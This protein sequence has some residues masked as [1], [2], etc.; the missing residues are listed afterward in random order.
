MT[1]FVF[2]V[3]PGCDMCRKPAIQYATTVAAVVVA[4]T[5]TWAVLADP[6]PLPGDL[7]LVRHA[8]ALGQPVPALAGFV[9]RTT[10][11]ESCLIATLPALVWLGRRHRRVAAGAL[12][13]AL[14]S[15]LVVQPVSKQ[16]VDRPRPSH[17]L[18]EV[19]AEYTSM[20]YPSGHSL[21]TTTTWGAAAGY[22]WRRGRRKW[23]ALLAMPVLLT[24]AS[25]SVQGVHWPSDAVAGT[26]IG[27][28]AAW[29]IVRAL[30]P[31]PA[32]PAVDVQSS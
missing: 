30:G 23:A 11:T 14:A 21:S 10:S 8:Q 4:V 2:Q 29:L 3:M 32:P 7:W 17:D 31:P 27:G 19:R 6:G 28:L 1:W 13:I 12:A 16:L 26:L 15:V 20:S 24:G 25:S 22:V 9:R 18:V 5:L